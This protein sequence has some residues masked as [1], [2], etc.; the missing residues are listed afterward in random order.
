MV[1]I[2]S[3]H[4][5]VITSPPS[6]DLTAGAATNTGRERSFKLRVPA[7]TRTRTHLFVWVLAA[8][9]SLLLLLRP[10]LRSRLFFRINLPPVTSARDLIYEKSVVV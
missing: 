10:C 7:L 8:P 2:I 1:W 3:D 9:L 5:E 6:P 4:V